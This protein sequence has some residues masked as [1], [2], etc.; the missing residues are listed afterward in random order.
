MQQFM[1]ND[2]DEYEQVEGSK[3]GLTPGYPMEEELEESFWVEGMDESTLYRP[4]SAPARPLTEL[5]EFKKSRI[6]SIIERAV[7]SSSQLMQTYNDRLDADCSEGQAACKSFLKQL[8]KLHEVTR[9]SSRTSKP[10]KLLGIIVTP[11]QMHTRCCTKAR[12]TYYTT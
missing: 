8:E 7:M 10:R 9:F 3:S 11:S 2:A 4:R 12:T 1:A 5:E 6:F